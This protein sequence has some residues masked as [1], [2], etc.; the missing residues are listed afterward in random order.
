VKCQHWQG[1]YGSTNVF[2]FPPECS[3]GDLGYL[4]CLLGFGGFSFGAFC[5]V[6]GCF[7]RFLV[8]YLYIHSCVLDNTTLLI[9]KKKKKKE[10]VHRFGI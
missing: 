7:F 1:F 9:K 10:F 2:S 4:V 5:R 6:L 8:G 3:R